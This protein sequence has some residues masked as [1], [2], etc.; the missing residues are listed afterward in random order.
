M[1][2]TYSEAVSVRR[3]A[4][5]RFIGALA[6]SELIRFELDGDEVMHEERLLGALK[7]RT[8]DVRHG[9]KGAL[10]VLTDAVDGKLLRIAPADL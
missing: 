7:Q 3:E 9:Q 10:Y 2:V 5:G 8:R 1:A 4:Q 6:S